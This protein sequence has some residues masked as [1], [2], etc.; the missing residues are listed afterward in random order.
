MRASAVAIVLALLP[1]V[2][3]AQRADPDRGP[4]LPSIGL[5]LPQIGLPLPDLGLPAPKTAPVRKTG[6]SRPGGHRPRPPRSVVYVVPAYVAA[7]AEPAPD[8]PAAAADTAEAVE[9]TAES[10]RESARPRGTL[11]LDLT[12]EVPV[13][14]HVDGFFIGTLD[15]TG[16]ELA[17]EPGPHQIEARADGYETVHVGVKIEENRTISYR[18]TLQRA[19][20]SPATP[21]APAASPAVTT[22]VARKPFYM[23]PGCYLGDVPP[24]QAKLPKSCDP[25]RS[26]TLWP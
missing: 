4:S 24:H 1:T 22:P 12:P 20:A 17:L 23:I 14:L 3:L 13:Q 15:E 7:P 25:A 8:A 5:P 9:A 2:A 19:E 16:F 18:A 26:V 6:P 21:A 11:R 10:T